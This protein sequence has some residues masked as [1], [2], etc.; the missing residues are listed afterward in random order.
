MHSVTSIQFTYDSKTKVFQIFLDR[1]CLDIQ[2]LKI[3]Y[4]IIKQYA[5]ITSNLRIGFIF[6]HINFINVDLKCILVVSME[7]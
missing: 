4:Y 2:A 7:Y 3:K 5:V 6:M 1:F